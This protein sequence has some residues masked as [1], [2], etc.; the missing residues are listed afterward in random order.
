MFDTYRIT[1]ETDLYNLHTHTQ[2]CD[3][4]AP[5]EDF[6]T[7][8]IEL[9]FTHLGITPHSPIS[10]ESPCNMSREQ[11]DEYFAE[12][13]RLRRTY[14]HRIN[15]YTAMEIDYVSVGDGPASDYFQ[16]MP[17]D[18]RIGSVHFIPSIGNPEVMVNIDG[19]FPDFKVRM[20]KYFDGDIEYV[21]KTFYSQMMAMVDEGGFEIVGHMDKIGFNASQYR[22]GID[23]EPWYDKLVIDLFENIMDHHMVIEINTKAWLQRNRFYPNLKY[24]GMLKRFNAPVVVNSDAHYPTLLNS[25]RMEAIKLLNV[26]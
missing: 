11:V 7:E 20:G 26:L 2:Y 17:L 13:E 1:R 15:L 21:V 24:F 23:E 6:V 10:I 5:M 14:G 4:H 19:K 25:G 8:A 12:M 22:D 18:Y 3:G 9:G 16:Q